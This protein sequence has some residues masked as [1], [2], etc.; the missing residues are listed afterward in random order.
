MHSHRRNFRK[1][2]KGDV[3]HNFIPQKRTVFNIFWSFDVYINLISLLLVFTYCWFVCL[4]KGEKIAL[5]F[6]QAKEGHS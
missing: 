1:I 3:S 4:G 2:T 6:C 5:L